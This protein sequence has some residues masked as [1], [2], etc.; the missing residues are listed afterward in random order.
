MDFQ[1]VYMVMSTTMLSISKCCRQFRLSCSLFWCQTYVGASSYFFFHT[2]ENGPV[3][4]PCCY[5]CGTPLPCSD[6]I[7]C[8]ALLTP[9]RVYWFPRVAPAW[10]LRPLE[11]PASKGTPTKLC[12][13]LKSA[14]TWSITSAPQPHSFQ[15]QQH[16]FEDFLAKRFCSLLFLSSSKRSAMHWVLGMWL[17][18][19]RL[20]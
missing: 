6:Q 3:K 19:V 5:N 15:P 20:S 16:K 2:K 14:S 4:T 12:K 17:L 13:R 9:A 7:P 1:Q 10:A 11:T 18:P 8:H